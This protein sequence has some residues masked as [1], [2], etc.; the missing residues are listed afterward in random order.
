[1][2]AGGYAIYLAKNSYVDHRLLDSRPGFD[3][4][5]SRLED[6]AANP[7][8]PSYLQRAP[9]NM[10]RR[11]RLDERRRLYARL[12]PNF[13][14]LVV[15]AFC[16]KREIAREEKSGSLTQHFV[17]TCLRW[18][19]FDILSCEPLVA[20]RDPVPA[21]QKEAP[22]IVLPTATS[23]ELTYTDAMAILR[24]LPRAGRRA[25]GDP[26]VDAAI[27]RLLAAPS[28]ADRVLVD[29][30]ES[31]SFLDSDRKQRTKNK[32]YAC[33]RRHHFAY[34]PRFDELTMKIAFEAAPAAVGR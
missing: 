13:K 28:W 12:F 7:N 32:L 15:T 33:L 24:P 25:A 19:K 26:L 11:I 29:L 9:L 3:E 8:H 17:D 34:S 22:K 30:P 4:L 10:F 6:L 2:E 27:E 18:R 21:L 1:M 5:L 31:W 14:I 16:T 23:R 20:W